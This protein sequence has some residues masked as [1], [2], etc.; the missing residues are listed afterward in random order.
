MTK[1]S[2]LVVQK[3]VEPWTPGKQFDFNVENLLEGKRNDALLINQ[4]DLWHC[5][6]FNDDLN[7]PQIHHFHQTNLTCEI[8]IK[9]AEPI[10]SLKYL[11]TIK[12]PNPPKLSRP[13]QNFAKPKEKYFGAFTCI[14]FFELGNAFY[15]KK[16]IFKTFR[17][18]YHKPY[19]ME[20]CYFN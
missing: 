13:L 7:F 14:Q 4:Y 17:T 8:F 20:K 5:H 16:C 1:W 10:E 18:I 19:F 6:T 2:S 11:K 3:V 9:Y 15:I 12:S